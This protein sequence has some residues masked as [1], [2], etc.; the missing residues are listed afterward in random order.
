[1]LD[2]VSRPLPLLPPSVGA[3]MKATWMNW[4]LASVEP[5][6]P[7]TTPTENFFA[8]PAG[9]WIAR[10]S[11]STATWELSQ[12]RKVLPAGAGFVDYDFTT[13]AEIARSEFALAFALWKSKKDR[14]HALELAKAARGATEDCVSDAT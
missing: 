10:N 7:V 8:S 11:V 3:L 9:W 6:R 12:P 14:P 2:W 5:A 4:P 13:E 1:L